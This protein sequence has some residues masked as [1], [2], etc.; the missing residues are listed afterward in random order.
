[1]EPTGDLTFIHVWLGDQLV[2]ASA[3][4][5]YRASADQPIRLEFD[6]DHLYLFDAQSKSAL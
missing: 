5:S 3:P 2:V 4:G 6:Q 1:V